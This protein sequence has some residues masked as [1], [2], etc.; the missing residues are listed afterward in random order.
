MDKKIIAIVLLV[1]GVALLFWGYNMT[2]SAGEQLAE[3]VTGSFSDKATWLMI[4][5]GVCA[6]IGVLQLVMGKK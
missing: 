5:G 1:V 6:L 3:A 4:G 2:Q